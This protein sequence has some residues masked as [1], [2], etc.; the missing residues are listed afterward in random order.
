M[1][2]ASGAVGFFFC[3]LM[4]MKEKCKDVLQFSVLNVKF[5]IKIRYLCDKF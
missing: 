4:I 3:H 5:Y 2:E 1:L